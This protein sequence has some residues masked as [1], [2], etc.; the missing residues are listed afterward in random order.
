L[1]KKS[2]FLSLAC[3]GLLV[4][5]FWPGPALGRAGGPDGNWLKDELAAIKPT[6]WQ[7]GELLLAPLVVHS[8]VTNP[9]PDSAPE[10]KIDPVLGESRLSFAL[11]KIFSRGQRKIYVDIYKCEQ[12]LGAWS[13]YSQYRKGA[14]TVIVRGDASSEDDDS[15]SFVKGRY[16]ISIYGTSQDDSESKD[17]VRSLADLL[18]QKISEQA[19]TPV[20]LQ[21][22]PQFELVR[23][24]EKILLGSNGLRRYLAVPGQIEFDW[25]QVRAVCIADYQVEVPVKERLRLA[26]LD[27]VDAACARSVYKSYIE[28][29]CSVANKEPGD[30]LSRSNNSFK[31][32]KGFFQVALKANQ[33]LFVL[34][35]KKDFS[36]QFL[37]RGIPN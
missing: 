31:T 37:L 6:G 3:S 1:L 25:T 29:Y 17:V 20:L 26:V 32:G 35:G 2:S 11:R 24:S 19:N 10:D 28:G 34:G 9:Q 15:V 5:L 36:G 18:C 22:M 23:G 27:C 33:V 14:S 13:L 4:G 30:R 7:E 8:A 21:H 16:F 12:P